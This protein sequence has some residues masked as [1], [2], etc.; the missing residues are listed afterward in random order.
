[1]SEFST[2][3]HNRTGDSKETLSRLRRGGFSG[4]AFPPANGRL[5]FAPFPICEAL[6]RSMHAG[7]P[8]MAVPGMPVLE[9]TFAEDHGWSFT[10]HRPEAVPSR[11]QQSWEG[12]TRNRH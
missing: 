10:L 12:R 8:L 5:T 1:M 9:Y 7:E 11:L 2:S 6:G 4:L 3:Y